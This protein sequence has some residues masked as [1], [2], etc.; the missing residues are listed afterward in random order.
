MERKYIPGIH[1]YTFIAAILRSSVLSKHSFIDTTLIH[2]ETGILNLFGEER[3]REKRDIENRASFVMI[4]QN[5]TSCGLV[6][7]AS[8]PSSP[9]PSFTADVS[10]SSSFLRWLSSLFS[11]G[12][13]ATLSSMLAGC[14]A[15]CC[16]CS[17]VLSKATL[18]SA[19]NSSCRS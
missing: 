13:L 14:W 4:L 6:S 16:C 8:A 19:F 7:M 11:G 9:S 3:E 18:Y 2:T 5:F 15:V 17:L 10:F 12:E 1:D